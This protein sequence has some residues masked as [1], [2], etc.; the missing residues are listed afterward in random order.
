[1]KSNSPKTIS[2]IIPV[3]NEA[4]YIVAMV[5]HLRKNSDPANIEEIIVVDGG[6]IDNTAALA[7]NLGT[8]VIKSPRGRAKQMNIGAAAAKGDILYFLHVD[9]LPPYS[10]CNRIIEAVSRGNIVGCFRMKFNSESYFLKSLA[11]F[12]RFNHSS[13]RGGDQSL[14]IIK[15]LFE[16][17][18]GFNEDYTIYED[19]EFIQRM[20]KAVAFSVLPQ[21]VLTSSRKYREKG[22]FKLQYHFCIIHAKRFFG[23]GPEALYEYY[24]NHIS[25]V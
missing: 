10:F 17:H 22:L 16:K 24:K 6:S 14:F 8:Q 4:A 12:T 18:K 3:L 5:Q 15:T 20:Y 13:C 9:T 21:Y 7:K 2:I 23:S 19:G 25:S 11:W 1:M